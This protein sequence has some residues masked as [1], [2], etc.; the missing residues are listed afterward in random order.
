[1]WNT[2]ELI[3][4]TLIFFQKNF[5]KYYIDPMG[6]KGL[7]CRSPH[8]LSRLPLFYHKQEGQSDTSH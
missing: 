8:N 5:L 4:F 6:E 1:M 7:P 2:Q 3:Q